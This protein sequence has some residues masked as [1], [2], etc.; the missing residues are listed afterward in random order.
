MWHRFKY[1]L[2]GQENEVQAW[3]TAKGEDELQTAMAKTVGLPL[4]IAGKL[5]LQGKLDSRGVVIPLQKELYEPILR[6]LK[7]LGVELE[8]KHS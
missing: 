6:E 3:L 8:E 4:A 1:V 2:D 5:L 7:S